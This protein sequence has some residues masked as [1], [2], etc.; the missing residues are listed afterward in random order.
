MW[1]RVQRGGVAGWHARRERERERERGGGGHTVGKHGNPS[2]AAPHCA[3]LHYTALRCFCS[4]SASSGFCREFA[5]CMPLPVLSP[6]PLCL[7]PTYLPTTHHLHTPPPTYIVVLAPIDIAQHAI[8]PLPSSRSVL[9]S[10]SRPRILVRHPLQASLA[11][12]ASPD[13]NYPV[14]STC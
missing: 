4:V 9:A 14:L 12:A 1:M 10:L 7:P 6:E 11:G 5:R 2:P 3:A 13:P 8:P